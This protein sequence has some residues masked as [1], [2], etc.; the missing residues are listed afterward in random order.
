MNPSTWTHHC[1]NG[2]G[3]WWG[4][5]SCHKFG[6]LIPLQHGLNATAYLS[7]V[8]D[9]V[10][11]LWPQSS[12]LLMTTADHITS[13]VTERTSSPAGWQWAWCPP[14]TSS[15]HLSVE[16]LRKHLV[17]TYLRCGLVASIKMEVYFSCDT[18]EWRRSK[19]FVFWWR[20]VCPFR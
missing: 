3:S 8:T 4:L 16:S 20:A 7:S 9:R 10:L 11:P 2:S 18:G 13:H 14:V 19:T 15:E 1:V 12:R 6:S 5:Y 17:I